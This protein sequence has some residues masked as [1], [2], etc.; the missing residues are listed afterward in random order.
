METL[1]QKIQ[2]DFIFAMKTKDSSAKSALSGLKTKITE[3]EKNKG[4]VDLNDDEVI[5]VISSSIKQRKQ[6]VDEFTKGNRFDLVEKEQNEILVLEKYL[7]KQMSNE[8]IE[9]TVR[10]LFGEITPDNNKNKMIGQLIGKFNKQYNGRADISFVKL[11][12]EKV[13]NDIS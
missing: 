4:N 2:E 6:S 3:A 8:E 10:L 13:M 9:T 1:K 7:P 11:F 12:A 5:K